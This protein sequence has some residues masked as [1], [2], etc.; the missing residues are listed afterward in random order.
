MIQEGV[1]RQ[2]ARYAGIVD[3]QLRGQVLEPFALTEV[4][5]GVVENWV[6]SKLQNSYN[7]GHSSPEGG[8]SHE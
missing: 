7:S 5:Q 8:E 6:P 4:L 3:R 2:Q 1:V